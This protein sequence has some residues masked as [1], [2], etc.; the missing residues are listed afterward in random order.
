[1][2]FANHVDDMS[3]GVQTTTLL[4]IVDAFAETVKR[5][6]R[7]TNHSKMKRTETNQD[8]LRQLSR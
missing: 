7:G 1:M 5:Q 6:S 3:C 4:F 8:S 2:E